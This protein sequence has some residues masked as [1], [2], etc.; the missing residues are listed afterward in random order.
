[1]TLANSQRRSLHLQGDDALRRRLWHAD[2]RHRHAVRRAMAMPRARPSSTCRRH[3][4]LDR[5]ASLRTRARTATCRTAEMPVIFTSIGVAEALLGPLVMAFSGRLVHQGQSPLA[6]LLGEEKYDRRISLHRRRD[7]GHAPGLASVRRRGRGQ[8]AHPADRQGRRAQLHVRPADRRPRA[9][10]NPPASAGRS[11]TTQ[12][13]IS[14][15]SL[16]FAEGDTTFEEMVRGVKEGIV[17]EELMGAGQ[18][19]VMGGDFSGNVLLGYKIENGEIVGRVKDTIV[20]GNVHDAL[21]Q[22]T[23]QSAARLAGLAA[24]S[25]RRRSCSSGSQSLPRDYVNAWTFRNTWTSSRD[26]SKRL[27]VTKL[28]RLSKLDSA[29]ARR[30]R[31]ALA[32]DRRPPPPP[33][34]AGAGRPL[35]GQRRSRLRRRLPARPP[36]RRQRRAPGVAARPLGGR[37]A[38]PDR[39]PRRPD[40]RGQEPGRARRSGARARP[41]RSA[42]RARPPARAP[43][44]ARRGGTATRHR[45]RQTRP[46]KSAPA[47]SKRSA[48]TTRPG[49]ARPS[50]TPTKAATTRS[51]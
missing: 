34:R 22:R 29:A 7:A 24:P 44:R 27:T 16:V 17:V 21:A 3:P 32:G 9:R 13:S 51:R 12:P 10:P 18:G 48:R 31:P 42:V 47:P 26:G 40:G 19:N 14:P 30:A 6:G 45:E 20:A 25:S 8:P 28:Q 41:L 36:R 38:G 23:S 2:P 43:L 15:S 5:A 33:H 1:M 4:G 49:C 35:R 50:R 39:Q 11:L 37:V 46:T